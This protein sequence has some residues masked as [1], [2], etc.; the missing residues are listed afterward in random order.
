MSVMTTTCNSLCLCTNIHDQHDTINYK[1]WE[2]KSHDMFCFN[3]RKKVNARTSKLQ[4]YIK[5]YF[6]FKR[7]PALNATERFAISRLKLISINVLS[8]IYLRFLFL[9]DFYLFEILILFFALCHLFIC[10]FQNSL[11]TDDDFFNRRQ[12]KMRPLNFFS[13]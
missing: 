9:W 10:Y 7:K 12:L 4:I 8:Q 6:I 2:I 1:S 3:V 5:T 13:N 11:L